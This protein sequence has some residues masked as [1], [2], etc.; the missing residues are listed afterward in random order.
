MSIPEYPAHIAQYIL[1]CLF[2]L[3]LLCNTNKQRLKLRQYPCRAPVC[4]ALILIIYGLSLLHTCLK[5]L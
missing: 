5:L 4:R 3:P 2:R 1:C